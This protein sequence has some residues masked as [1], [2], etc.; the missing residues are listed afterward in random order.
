MYEDNTKG[1]ENDLRQYEQFDT[2]EKNLEEEKDAF[3]NKKIP[4]M[5]IQCENRSTV[6]DEKNSPFRQN[7][8]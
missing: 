6:G 2:I 4:D 1:R 7:I 8:L 3:H 5:V